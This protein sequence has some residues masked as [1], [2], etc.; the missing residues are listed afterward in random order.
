[1]IIED[2]GGDPALEVRLGGDAYRAANE[3]LR[4]SPADPDGNHGRGIR[5][6]QVGHAESPRDLKG[7]KIEAVKPGFEQSFAKVPGLSEDWPPQAA[8]EEEGGNPLT[9]F[10]RPCPEKN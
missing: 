7:G 6:V 4:G 3:N 1:L 10:A 8:H 5:E 9:T 2:E